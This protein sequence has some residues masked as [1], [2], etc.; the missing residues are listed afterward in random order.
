[1]SHELPQEVANLS[2][3]DAKQK[4]QSLMN[5]ELLFDIPAKCSGFM[6][7]NVITRFTE[8]G[9]LDI[10]KDLNVNYHDPQVMR[11]AGKILKYFE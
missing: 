9:G 11:R 3:G 5:I 6:L 4:L 10:I 1:M 7:Q 2:N 8:I